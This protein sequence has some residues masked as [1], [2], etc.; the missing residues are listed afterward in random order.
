MAVGERGG[1]VE[2][3]NIARVCPY[4]RPIGGAGSFVGIRSRSCDRIA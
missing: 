4:G 2:Q 3:D 1:Y